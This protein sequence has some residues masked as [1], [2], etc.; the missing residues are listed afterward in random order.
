MKAKSYDP[1]RKI[2]AEYDL[3]MGEREELK[4]LKKL[5]PQSH[6]KAET[7]LELAC[8]TGKL[9]KPFSVKYRVYGLDRSLPM[10]RVAKK[11]IRNAKFY[12]ADMTNFRLNEKFDIIICLFNSL[13]HLASFAEWRRTFKNAA[14]HLNRGGVF[15]FDI[16][17]P[18]SLQTYFEEPVYLERKGKTTIITE[19]LEFQRGSLLMHISIFKERSDGLFQL[20]ES[21]IYEKAFPVKK[22]ESEL[23]KHF[24]RIQIMDQ[25]GKRPSKS[26]EVLYFTCSKR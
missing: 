16:N 18:H 12:H 26:S 20:K 10:I 1:Y 19:F 22:I 23:K 6:P 11:R 8:G 7:I 21:K 15:I 4:L 24:G 17:T 14:R 13:N 5:I 3:I 9:L 2:A 25:S